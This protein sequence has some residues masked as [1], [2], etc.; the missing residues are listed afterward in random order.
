VWETSEY[1]MGRVAT[2]IIF[3]ELKAYLMKSEYLSNIGRMVHY[4]GRAS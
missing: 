4:G 2:Y 1:M 3:V